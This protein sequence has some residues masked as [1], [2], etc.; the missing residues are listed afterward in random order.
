MYRLWFLILLVAL[1]ACP[2][3]TG[4]G[5]V[6]GTVNIGTSAGTSA[7]NVG[8]DFVAGE[9]IVRFKSAPLL[10]SVQISQARG[11]VLQQVESLGVAGA[12]LYRAKADKTQTLQ[13][14]AE[15][16]ARSDVLYAH[17][18]YLMQALATPNDA[19]FAEQWD[20]AAMKLPEAWDL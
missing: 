14:I 15:L 13:M 17:P 3:F 12:A 5:D 20:L 10:Q 4:P 9:V 2:G 19:R 11:V 8:M 18:N 7:G 6:S 16:E 1:T